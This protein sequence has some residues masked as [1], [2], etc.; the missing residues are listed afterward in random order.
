MAKRFDGFN[1]KEVSKQWP[2][3]LVFNDVLYERT[4]DCLINVITIR[5]AWLINAPS[6]KSHYLFAKRFRGSWLS[7]FIDKMQ[8]YPNRHGVAALPDKFRMLRDYLH[9]YASPVL[10][11]SILPLQAVVV[12][13]PTF[14]QMLRLANLPEAWCW[15]KSTFSR[16]T[17]SYKFY[18]SR[19]LL[20][21]FAVLFPKIICFIFST[22]CNKAQV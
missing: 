12:C 21:M 18:S 1:I 4:C 8:L 7:I 9:A 22:V 13:R 11:V 6:R 10:H 14:C 16:Y 2:I 3:A 19:G 17:F 15:A 5:D 20:P